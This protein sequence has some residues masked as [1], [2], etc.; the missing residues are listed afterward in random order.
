MTTTTSVAANVPAK[1][2]QEE[3]GAAAGRTLNKIILY[4]LLIVIG[5]ILFMPFIL[6]FVSTFKTDAE[7]IA[8]PPKFFP[9][10]WLVEN[11]PKLW[12]TDLGGLPR[13]QGSTS[14]GLV[15][16]MLTFFGTL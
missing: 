11:W 12:S 5:L 4:V 7:I 8:W 9:N 14:L 16:G 15:A 1:R 10:T 13:P 2:F 3:P 6:A